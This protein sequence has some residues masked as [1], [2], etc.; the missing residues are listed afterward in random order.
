MSN[1]DGTQASGAGR[2]SMDQLSAHIDRGWDLVHRGD[3][4]GAQTSAEKSLELDAESPEAYNLLGYARAALGDHENALEHYRYAIA[5]DDTFVEAMLNA[6]EVLIHPIHD[7]EGAMDLVDNAL[8]FI[9]GEDERADALLVKFDAY[10]HQGEREAA[11]RVLRELPEGP[12]ESPRLEFLLGRAHHDVG[13]DATALPYLERAVAHDPNHADAFHC[14]GVAF[15]AL[16]RAQD[17]TLA[18]LR[19][20]ELDAHAPRAPW[21]LAPTAFERLAREIVDA[22]PPE[23]R[24]PIEGALVVITELPGPEMI[25]DGVDPR[26]GVLLDATSEPPA[27]PRAQRVFVYQ[28]NVER[29]SDGPDAVAEE[30]RH[31]LTTELAGVFPSLREA[32]GIHDADAG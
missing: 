14:L 31:A 21:S 4:A 15:D 27:P 11:V 8:D 28:R 23:L 12:F 30:L 13:E 26:T 24:Q 22:L 32:A 25:A 29:M 3:F 5:L 9:E 10:L 17:A 2:S 19:A 20:R 6:A 16:G 1:D 18:L 7:F